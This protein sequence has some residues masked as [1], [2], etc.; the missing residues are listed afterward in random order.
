MSE[1]SVVI[2]NVVD[3]LGN[4]ADRLISDAEKFATE[5]IKRVDS[6]AP[7]IATELKNIG[8]YAWQCLVRQQLAEGIFYT[9]AGV[10]IPVLFYIY[11][12][13]FVKP[14]Y[15]RDGSFNDPLDGGLTFFSILLGLGTIIVSGIFLFNGI[16][17]LSLTR[18]LCS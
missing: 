2:N 17:H 16:T 4:G 7:Q 9:I 15:N 1:T 11:F 8:L 3:K 10:M 12:R 5:F 18:I 13:L 14:H 6:V